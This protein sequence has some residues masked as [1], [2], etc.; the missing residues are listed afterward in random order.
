[1]IR[2]EVP[3]EVRQTRREAIAVPVDVMQAGV[4]R[5]DAVAEGRHDCVRR[6]VADAAQ[7]VEL[8]V[9]EQRHAAL[10]ADARIAAR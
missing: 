1:M 2:K 3:R 7:R 5:P 6:R 10:P 4:E 9:R 8:R